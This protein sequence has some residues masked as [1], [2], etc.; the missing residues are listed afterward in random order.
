[1]QIKDLKQ[2]TH[3]RQDLEKIM[4]LFRHNLMAQHFYIKS[5]SLANTDFLPLKSR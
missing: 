3:L 4:G 1:M 5:R 2:A